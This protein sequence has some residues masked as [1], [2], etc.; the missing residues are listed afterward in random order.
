MS[1]IPIKD[2]SDVTRKVDVIVRTEGADTVETQAVAVVD[3]ATG[4]PLDFATQTTL[5][6]L[7]T[8]ANA[9]KAAAEAMN[10]KTTAIN[11]GAVAGTVALDAS[12]L[13]ALETVAA[14]VTGAVSVSNFP[15]TQAVADANVASV[16]K[17]KNSTASLTDFGQVVLA[18]RRDTD[19]AETTADG[20]YTP[21]KQDQAG[22]L[23]VAT[24]PGDVTAST[25]T[26]TAAAQQV[27][28]ATSRISN[29]SI[30][31][32]AAA[33][34]GHNS[35]FEVS[36]DST[37]GTNGNW[38]TV[39]V[40]RTDSNI[41]ETTTGVLAATPAYA[42]ELNVASFAWF[43]VR[44][45][46]HTSGTATYTL[47]PGAYATEP[48]PSSQNPDLIAYAYSVA[49]VVAINTDLIVIDCA[50]FKSLSI[51]CTSM[52]T[53]GVVT[54]QWS[55][56]VSF[57]APITATL[58]S[59]S[60]ASSTTFNAAVLRNVNVLARYFRLR[61][62]TATTAGTT[63]L[64][65]QASQAVLAPM[66]ATQP[67]S[68][69]VTANI[70]TGSLAAGTNAV[71]DVGQQYRASATGAASGAHIV[72]A[73]TTNATIV[74]AS[75]GKVVGWNLVNTTAV[76]QYVKLHNQATSPTAGA[77]VVRTIGVPPNGSREAAFEGGIAFTTG[78]GMTIVTG[79]ADADATATTAGAVVGDLFF[80]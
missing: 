17:Q 36:N 67:V 56:D 28:I 77:G 40:V 19:T 73:A 64:N 4:T 44:N 21:L 52:G 57:A 53:T 66:V 3:P 30:A 35:I 74:K 49:G 61:L 70:G 32:V 68:G 10:A 41:I 63:T 18:Q 62:T 9:I 80:A 45:T 51:Q 1:N 79:S 48:V 15:A 31:M 29:L 6:A 16:T 46:A 58:L 59:E 5:A 14:I 60:G 26:I 27:A 37:D 11:T 39:Q 72:S 65:V 47:K 55:N 25:G 42:W 75:A 24:Q 38:K 33:L 22:R 13:A 50:K 43:R 23:K 2:A 78:I 71:G 34:V 54:P 20:Q 8:A 69:T 7:L 12:S 76:W